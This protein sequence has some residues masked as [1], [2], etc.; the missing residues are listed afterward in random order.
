MSFGPPTFSPKP[1]AALPGDDL[2]RTPGFLPR[3]ESLRGVAAF[4]VAAFHAS[5]AQWSEGKLIVTAPDRD[6]PL[7]GLILHAMQALFNGH[8]AVVMFF[9]ISGFV[10]SLS[11]ASGPQALAPAARRF[12]AA[13]ILR[14]Y[15][16]VVATILLFAIL[17]R[18]FGLALEGSTAEHY[19]ASGLLRHM[20][21]LDSRINGVLWTLQLEVLAVPAIFAMYF[22]GR[23]W[24]P[25]PILALAIVLACLSFTK[26]YSKLL[27]PDAPGLALFYAFFIGMLLPSQGPRW[28]ASIERRGAA[29]A[30]LGAAF[31]FIL[32]RPVIGWT[33]NFAPL[34]EAIAAAILLMTMTYGPD[35]GGYRPLD[36]RPVRFLGRISYSFYLLHPLTLLALWSMPA[37]VDG[38][39]ALGIPSPLLVLALVA[40]STLAIIP[41]ASASYRWIERPC[42]ELGRRLGR[43]RGGMTPA[44][45]AEPR[46]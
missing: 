33:S 12:F 44:Y 41:L 13:R 4:M 7:T 35:L 5:Q 8:G 6:A 39:L 21:L 3:V 1:Q 26:S 46:R 18:V 43:A 27:G 2:A 38:L 23:R 19:T 34:A 36:W 20:L 45:R 28:G 29:V 15:P 24:G 31:A 17:F 10:L 9:V 11:L 16:A 32:A 14:I 30:A 37:T 22:V 42:I 25:A 40:A